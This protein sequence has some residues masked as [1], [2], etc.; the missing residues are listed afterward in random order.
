MHGS[1]EEKLKDVNCLKHAEQGMKRE[2][3]L[4]GGGGGGGGGGDGSRE[5]EVRTAM[6]VNQWRRCRRY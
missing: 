2:R 4:T 1:K 3:V 6:E 5:M